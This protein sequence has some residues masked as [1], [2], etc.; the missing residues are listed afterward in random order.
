MGITESRWAAAVALVCVAAIWGATFVIVAD[1]IA[2]YPMYA[3]LG[4]RFAVATVAFVALFPR[5]VAHLDGAN[6]RMGLLAGVFLAAGYIF[7]TWGLDGERATTPARAAFITGLYVVIVPLAQALVL[8]KLPRKPTI[9]GAA[10][11]LVGLWMLSG[12]DASGLGGWVTG[13]T[14]VVVCA[15]AYSVHMLILGSTDERHDTAALTLVQ[16]LT[17]TA[18]TSAISLLTEDAGLP[19]RVDVLVAIAICGVLASALAFAIQTWAQRRMP[20]ARVALIL[21]TEPAFGG[22]IG[23]SV[24]GVWPVMEM[25]GASMMLGG[26]ITSE[27]VAA[28]TTPDEGIEFEAGLEGMPAPVVEVEG[29]ARLASESFVDSDASGADSGDASS[30]NVAI[31]PG[32]GVP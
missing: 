5:S 13:D 31:D 20:P 12:V 32:R 1:A 26:M 3:F 21:V 27:V 7:Q 15:V 28:A 17:V 9:V 23:W 10:M 2:A 29:H 18:I 25:L 4:W 6:L 8:R 22:L 11:A 24:A 16:L 19:T 14:L 30:A